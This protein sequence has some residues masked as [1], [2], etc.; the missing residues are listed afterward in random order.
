M[1]HIT[2]S[3]LAENLSYLGTFIVMALSGTLVPVPEEIMLLLIGYASGTGLSNIYLTFAAAALG[4][5][6]GDSVLFFLS[7]KGNKFVSKSKGL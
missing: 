5:M 3:A 4:V 1:D 7:L 2:V 6:V